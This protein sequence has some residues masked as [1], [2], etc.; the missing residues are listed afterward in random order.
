MAEVAA[1]DKPRG[2]TSDINGLLEMVFPGY[3]FIRNILASLGFD[4]TRII[5]KW[6]PVVALA[7]LVRY[8]FGFVRPW[9]VRSMT[10]DISIPDSVILHHKV[11]RWFSQNLTKRASTRS[12]AIRNVSSNNRGSSEG[13]DVVIAPGLT[14]SIADGEFSFW[15]EGRYFMG[16]LER[17][18]SGGYIR[19]R[20]LTLACFGQSTAPL[21]SF[22]REC[23]K[24]YDAQQRSWTTIRTRVNGYWEE[25]LV[26]RSRPIETVYFDRSTIL[27]FLQDVRDYRAPGAD[28]YYARRGIPYR[29]GYLFYGPPGTGKSSL[30][31]ALA[32]MCGS[33]LY[34]MN[35]AEPSL[36]D[37]ELRSALCEVE[38][39]AILLIEDV[40]ALKLDNRI[41]PDTSVS[42]DAATDAAEGSTPP[43]DGDAP[44]PPPGPG[45]ESEKKSSRVTLSG[46]L[47]AIDGV[48]A[49]EGRVL[50][51][52]TNDPEALDKALVRP[53]RVDQM[54]LFPNLSSVQARKMFLNFFDESIGEYPIRD[55]SAATL[56]ALGADEPSTTLS[57]APPG[58]Q[59]GQEQ[60]QPATEQQNITTMAHQLEALVAAS[61]EG[62]LTPAELQGYMLARR[63]EPR[64]VLEEFAGWIGGV[65]EAKKRGRNVVAE[66]KEKEGQ[67]AKGDE[68][69]TA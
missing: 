12:L 6:V 49:A 45:S 9:L 21:M 42:K 18:K 7:A 59:Q 64:R 47:N 24:S 67:K 69:K 5:S 39:D 4:A 33:D 28:K 17:S 37:E 54:L 60:G 52:T 34:Y 15:W 65:K 61:A 68:K 13:S 20:V 35:L 40:D 3:G 27:P 56:D 31:F 46:L 57:T 58:Q 32:G 36:N 41:I 10:Y 19:H 55:L 23:Q 38:N 8:V 11:M 51:M 63:K 1:T 16:S 62:E 43:K 50:I 48:A 22:L 2:E 25:A 14:T 53:G 66:G 44:P 26:K 29:R 30:S